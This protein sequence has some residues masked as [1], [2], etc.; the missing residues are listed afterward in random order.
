MEKA[1]GKNNGMLLKIIFS[2]W[3][4]KKVSIQWNVFFVVK[5]STRIFCVKFITMG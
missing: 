5:S 4:E 3:S 2:G 1:N